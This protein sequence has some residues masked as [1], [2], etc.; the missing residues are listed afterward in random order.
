MSRR[1]ITRRRGFAVAAGVAI[2]LV[3][4]AA[5]ER[6]HR[7]NVL[8]ITIDTTRADRL[9]CY[10]FG[11]AHTPAIDRLAREGVRCLDA[12]SSAPITLPAHCSIMTGLYPPAHGVRDNGNYALGPEAVTLAERLQT[13][14]YHTGAF[15]SAAV[16]TRRYGL[17][18]GFE[19]YDDDL[20]SEDEPELFMIRER[21]ASR[22]A[23][24]AL[25]WL[26]EWRTHARPQPFF[27][28]VHF[29]D[30]HQP[31]DVKSID[32]AAL[33]PTPYDA[34]IAEADRG[35][36]RL[37]DWLRTQHALD[38]TLVVLTADHGESLG[39]HGEPTHGVFIYDAT[40][41]VPLI[42]RLPGMLPPGTTYP[43]PVRHIDIVPTIL[44]VLGLPGGE[45]T[46]GANLLG[47]LQ[48]RTPPL[49]LTQYSEARL[50]EEG[51]GMA[52]LFGVRHDGRKWI[53]A[54]HPELYDLHGDPGELHNLYPAQAAAARPLQADL[55]SVVADS[56]RRALTAPTREIDRETEDML[57]ALGYLAPPEQRAEMGGMDPKDGM[58]LYAKLQEARQLA[59]EGEWERT[60]ALLG[61]VLAVAP[62][63]VTA[64][65]VLALAAVRRGDYDEAERQYL[66][67]LERQPR[68]HRVMGA[69]GAL[70]LRRGDLDGAEQ[71]FHQAL[72][73][74]PS[75]VEAMSNLGWI[76]ATRGNEAR[77]AGLVRAS[78]RARPLVSPRLPASRGPV[79]RPSG[80]AARARVLSPRP[81]GAAAVLRG[82]HPGGQQRALRR[83]YAVGVQLLRGGG[84]RAA[85]FLDP[86]VQSRVSA[87][88]R[89]RAGRGAGA[90]RPG[91]R[92]GL[93]VDESPRDQ[94]GLRHAADASR[95]ERAARA[96]RGG[97]TQGEEVT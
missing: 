64:R 43:G 6:E 36:G 67:S 75:Y 79:L 54:P 95:M 68:Q 92:P 7:P 97:R 44:A 2:A 49:D 14:G 59:Q 80:L 41:R 50:A 91:G 55:E 53:Q 63:N 78:H 21:P 89:R 9:G 71:R 4:L 93:R 51:F 96:G 3:A 82:A 27:L 56:G 38:D 20:W 33:T 52:P 69:L 32:L 66:A 84:S 60:Q 28:W 37:I 18:Q 5:C 31:Y 13:S 16:L 12:T 30:P 81:L 47:A 17:D 26:E 45:T 35:V 8:V 90:A 10:G 40:I 25:S 65:N 94:R 62:E 83:R 88:A 58:A 11:L 22:T 46:Q 29:F 24:R 1:L 34:E 87:R 19:V 85:R 23:D 86:A 70:A 57:R 72:D 42:W 73:L 48:G 61:E 76:E 74:A 39:E 77:G 15:V